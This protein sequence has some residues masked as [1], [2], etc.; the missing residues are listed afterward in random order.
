MSNLKFLVVDDDR[1]LADSIVE[2][3]EVK[4]HDAKAVYSGEEGVGCAQNEDFDV[5]FMDMVM[6]GMNG[7]EAMRAIKSIAPNTQIMIMTGYSSDELINSANEHGVEQVL[8]KPVELERV[9]DALKVEKSASVVLLV[10]DDQDF[11]DS[12]RDYLAKHGYTLL[13]AQDGAEATKLAASKDVEVVLLDL[14]LPLANG[15]DIFL[16]LKRSGNLRPTIVI[17]GCAGQFA[18]EIEILQREGAEGCFVKP[19]D[20]SRLVEAIGTLRKKGRP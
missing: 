4:G 19:I 10:D 6:P 7:V 5:I 14:D 16:Q 9:L 18:E 13:T 3:L 2:I 11:A 1:D 12:A 20:P 17:T 15:A 8:S